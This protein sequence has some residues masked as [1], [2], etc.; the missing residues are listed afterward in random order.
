L[1][2]TFVYAK[3]LRRCFK[4]VGDIESMK[5]NVYFFTPIPAF[6]RQGGRGLKSTI[7]SVSAPSPLTGEGWDGGEEVNV[8]LH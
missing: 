5:I 7:A 4:V 1:P 3:K 8:D 6:P 2:T